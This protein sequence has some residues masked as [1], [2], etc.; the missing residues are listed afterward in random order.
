[1][2]K[3]DLKKDGHQSKMNEKSVVLALEKIIKRQEAELKLSLIGK[4]E[5]RLK[6]EYKH[7][8]VPDHLYWRKTPQQ[9]EAVFTK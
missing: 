4:G 5:Y 8:E 7:L 1:M 9:R 6:E 3:G 2:I